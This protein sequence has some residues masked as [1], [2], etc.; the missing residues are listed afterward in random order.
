MFAFVVA[1]V[2]VVRLHSSMAR[3]Q[4]VQDLGMCAVRDAKH[5]RDE[6]NCDKTSLTSHCDADFFFLFLSCVSLV[7][8]SSLRLSTANATYPRHVVVG[9]VC[10][11]SP[12][13]DF[14]K[15]FKYGRSQSTRNAF[16]A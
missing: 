4:Q 6:S 2:S 8:R 11:I 1:V 9:M 14:Q 5:M 15:T 10:N 3:H 16:N 12:P 7:S 13:D